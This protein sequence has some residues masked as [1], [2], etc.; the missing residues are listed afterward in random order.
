MTSKRPGWEEYFMNI[1][2][3]VKT[4]SLDNYKVGSVLVSVKNNR[5]ISTGYNSIASK[6]NDHEIDWSQRDKVRDIV[7]HAEMNVL[8]YC[9]SKFEESILYTTSSPCVSCLKMLS[10]SKI[11]KIIYKQEYKDID[12]VKKLADFFKIELIEYSS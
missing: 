11:K 10:A 1:C 3:V 8:L 2:E 6:L 7:I 5:I 4:R 9:E 12:K